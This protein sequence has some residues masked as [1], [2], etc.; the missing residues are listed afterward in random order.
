MDRPA[1]AWNALATLTGRDPVVDLRAF[2]V[3]G[4][5][6]ERLMLPRRL[7]HPTFA[8][9]GVPPRKSLANSLRHRANGIVG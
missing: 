5:V 2:Q 4:Q 7:E 9:R 3:G 1:P 8:L 6:F